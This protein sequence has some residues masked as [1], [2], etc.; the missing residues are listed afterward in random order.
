MVARL[1]PVGV[2]AFCVGR[3]RTRQK[4]EKWQKFYK[5]GRNGGAD[6]EWIPIRKEKEGEKKGKRERIEKKKKK[7]K[8]KKKKE[9]RKKKKEKEERRKGEKADEQR[10]VWGRLRPMSRCGPVRGLLGN[11][12]LS[13]GTALLGEPVYSAG[14]AGGLCCP[15]A[16]AVAGA[17]RAGGAGAASGGGAI[18]AWRAVCEF[19]LS[20]A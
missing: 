10:F 17:W 3:G 1:L 6:A 7:E 14:W 13:H 11:R 5:T 2:G 16:G 8:R 9:K 20:Y 18:A 12:G 19:S 15:E 4:N